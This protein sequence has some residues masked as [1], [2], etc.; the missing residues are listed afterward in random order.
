[1]R[2]TVR[3]ED[4]LAPVEGR[5]H[6]V[7]TVRGEFLIP[8]KIRF[9]GED[10]DQRWNDNASVED[11]HHEEDDNQRKEDVASVEDRLL[12]EDDDQ[13]EDNVHLVHDSMVKNDSQG[14]DNANPAKNTLHEDDAGHG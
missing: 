4:N 6:R 12:E 3:S 2:I 9:H 1:M 11:S 13:V 5:F 14:E 8:W 10:D 7:I